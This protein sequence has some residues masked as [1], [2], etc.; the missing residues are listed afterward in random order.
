MVKSERRTPISKALKEESV[1]TYWVLGMPEGQAQEGAWWAKGKKLLWGNKYAACVGLH[2]VGEGEVGHF[3]NHFP[4]L[5]SA[6]SRTLVCSGVGI[7]LFLFRSPTSFAASQ[8][9]ACCSRREAYDFKIRPR[10]ALMSQILPFHIFL[11]IRILSGCLG[12]T[13]HIMGRHCLRS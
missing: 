13:A 9:P 6:L 10:I 8:H 12:I 2:P 7:S 5:R 1:S 4:Q 3:L 11:S